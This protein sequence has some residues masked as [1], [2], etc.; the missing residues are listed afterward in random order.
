[1]PRPKSWFCPTSWT[2][3]EVP[4][5]VPHNIPLAMRR[6]VAVAAERPAF[7]LIESPYVCFVYHFL[8]HSLLTDIDTAVKAKA[9]TDGQYSVHCNLLSGSTSSPNA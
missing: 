7:I 6:N 5:V 4:G 3:R 9:A 8:E 2:F 1:M